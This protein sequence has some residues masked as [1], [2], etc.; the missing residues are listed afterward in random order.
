M[1]RKEILTGVYAIA[2][3]LLLF[4]FIAWTLMPSKAS[5]V[6]SNKSFVYTT[7]LDKLGSKRKTESYWTASSGVITDQWRRS[8]WVSGTDSEGNP[9]S[10]I[11]WYTVYEYR[12][13]ELQHTAALRGEENPR[14][15]DTSMYP[16]SSEWRRRYSEELYWQ[17]GELSLRIEKLA[18]WQQFSVG[19]VLDVTHRFGWL[20]SA[21][22]SIAEAASAEDFDL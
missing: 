7:Y 12:P 14:H 15:A 22:L 16:S 20:A 10:E 8:R 2:L 4:A 5:G 21:K 17:I 11:E 9:T 6:L 13:W 1:A 19:D 3:V 18:D